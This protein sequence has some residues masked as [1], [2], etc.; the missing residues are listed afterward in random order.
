VEVLVDT[1][2]IR[3]IK[4]QIFRF[5]GKELTRLG[6]A[7]PGDPCVVEV[8]GGD[9]RHRPPA[10]TLSCAFPNRPDVYAIGSPEPLVT[11]QDVKLLL[12]DDWTRPK[13]G[14]I[15]TIQT[16]S[17][18]FLGTIMHEDDGWYI[19]WE[20]AFHDAIVETV[21]AARQAFV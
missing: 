7:G 19:A 16:D 9:P 11:I 20:G 6:G 4:N 13:A 15:V 5:G 21:A 10:I 18:A 14:S 3:T 17:G 12:D 1:E 8:A 2:Q